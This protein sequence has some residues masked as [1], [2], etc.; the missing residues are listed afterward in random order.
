MATN[1]LQLLGGNSVTENVVINGMTNDSRS[2]KPG[3]LF[4]ALPGTEVDGRDFIPDAIKRGAAAI[5]T[6]D[7]ANYMNAAGGVPVIEDANPRR[8]Y[9]QLAARFAGLQPEFQVAVTGTNGKTSVADFARQLWD[10][11][12]VSSASIGT[13]GVRSAAL[14]TE[15]GLTTPDPLQ[16]HATLADL[17]RANVDHVA[18]EA[19][20]HGLDQHRLDGLRLKAAAFTNL[21]RDHLDYHKT[22]QAYFYAKARLFGDLLLPGAAAVIN[23]DDPW[24]R[25]LDD[26]AWGRSLTR[27]TFGRHE[28]AAL[29]LVDAV[30]LIDGQHI[31]VAFKGDE[32]EVKLPLIGE[33]QA[34]NALAAAG[35]VM[36]AGAEASA[37]FP[38]LETL[39]GV[40]GRLE[41]IGMK[42]SASLFVDY[43]H[44]PDGLR[45]VLASARAH[46]P[47]RLHVVFG[48]GGDRDTGKRPQM[49]QIASELAD[50]VYVTD[51]NP[52]SEN[53][54]SIRAQIMA[55]CPE[56]VEIGDRTA[57]IKAA[58]E[59][60]NP[61]DMVIVA[62][63]G[64][65]TG[66]ILADHTIDYSD[67]ETVRAFTDA[68]DLPMQGKD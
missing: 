45:T 53:P 62:G 66:Q 1:L 35:L 43:A 63:K 24:G 55:A 37:V 12:G 27:Y 8:R 51:D 10:R 16:L 29:K 65:E 47:K 2:V 33:F 30:P 52:R 50:A 9:A 13:L 22:E 59:A 58:A 26:I 3:D 68:C 67:I 61:G 21:T 36:A 40:P 49:G 56:A 17:K 7:A 34:M 41:L 4:V 5:L 15:G 25:I 11:L 64:H 20:S 32:F 46:N 54:A 60:A 39:E 42:N 19:S 57:A 23:I 31:V 28:R 38:A 6:F 14:V 48:C 18:I 44:T